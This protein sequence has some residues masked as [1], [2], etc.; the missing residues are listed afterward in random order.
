ME[1]AIQNIIDKTPLVHWVII[2]ALL[3][4]LLIQLHFYFR[5]YN[6]II[7]YNRKIS[8]NKVEFTTSRPPVSVIVY[9]KN[10]VVNLEKILPRILRQKYPKFE[11]IVVNDG[12]TDQSRELLEKLDK[13]YSNLYHTFL[14]MKAKYASRKKM[15]IAV[16]IKAAH[17]EHLM[18]VDADCEPYGEHWL[19]QM[20]CNYTSE[21]DIVLGYSHPDTN[22]SFLG[23]LIRFDSVMNAMRYMG[24]A[25]NGNPYRGTGKNLSYK[26]SLF[27]GTNGYAKILNL[28]AGEDSLFIQSI[29]SSQN[30]RV[31]FSPEATTLCHREESTKTYLYQKEAE[32]QSFKRYKK[33]VLTYLL[34]EDFSRVFFYLIGIASIIFFSCT[35]NWELLAMSVF[36]FMFRAITQT[37]VIRKNEALLGEEKHFLSIPLFDFILPIISA[38]LL[39]FWQIG[40]KQ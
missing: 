19:A 32:L 12:S 40:K 34:A 20:M 14:P 3:L 33:K 8:K 10:E 37:I 4:L 15:C 31:E 25:L 27:F 21:T 24:F 2:G 23:K 26:K 5:Y 35:Q 22:N 11:V 16:G 7:Q 29:A 1:Q 30:T 28:A 39:T 17:Y 6:K 18:F 9:A 36:F 13:E 38:Y